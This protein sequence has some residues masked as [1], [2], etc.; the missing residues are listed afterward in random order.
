[1]IAVFAISGS[2]AL[3]LLVAIIVL[4][5]LIPLAGK[6]LLNQLGAPMDDAVERRGLAGWMDQ[7]RKRAAAQSYE[8]LSAK[9]DTQRTGGRWPTPS[10][11]RG[12][13]GPRL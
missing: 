3:V 10:Q 11:R 12:R 1:M 4:F 9:A 7:R 2:G 13:G 6:A 8:G 5:V